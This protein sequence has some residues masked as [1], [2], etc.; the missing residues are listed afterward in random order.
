LVT[1]VALARL[2]SDRTDQGTRHTADRSTDCRT[3]NIA[4]GDAANHSAGCCANAGTLFCCRAARKRRADHQ[5]HQG[6]LHQILLNTSS[7]ARH[8]FA[9]DAA[10]WT[11]K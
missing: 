1:V 6:L 7:V 3:A 10:P 2:F 8:G 9:P 11:N 5:K 4:S